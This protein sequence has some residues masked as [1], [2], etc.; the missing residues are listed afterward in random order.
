MASACSIPVRN[1]WPAYLQVCGEKEGE[2]EGRRREEGRG[3]GG[4]GRGE[5]REGKRCMSVRAEGGM[6]WF[7]T[8][9]K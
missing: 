2:R 3:G 9:R 8:C 6:C 7:Y 1:Q 4:M 5:G